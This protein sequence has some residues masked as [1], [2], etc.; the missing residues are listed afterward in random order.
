[1]QFNLIIAAKLAIA[2]GLFLA[3]IGYLGYEMVADK[4]AKIDFAQKE[5][6]GLRYVAEVR[7]VQDAVVRGA[8]MAGLAERVKANEKA[9][10]TDLKT[11]MATNSLLKALAGTDHRAAAQAAA[12][13]IGKAADGSNLTLD[14]DLDSFYTQD[15][16]T[17][18][19][20]AAVAGVASLATSV[21][22]TAGRDILVDDQVMIGV[23]G[24]ALQPTLDGLASDIESAV[25]GNPDKTVDGAVSAPV[26]KVTATAKT[27]LA[28]LAD[29]AR[30]ADAQVVAL[31]LLDA[32]KEAGAADADQSSA[33]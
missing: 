25:Q 16:L 31:P 32:I 7:A 8:D 28:L 19:V 14:P 30:A 24:G 3:P 20:P 1:M 29:H 6:S 11:A 23:Q 17:V 2:Y 9:R 12:D 13:L 21:A 26:A 33:C 4:E 27:A 22:D 15:T 18:K 10:G 5:V